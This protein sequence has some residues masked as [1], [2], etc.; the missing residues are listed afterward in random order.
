MET[1]LVGQ[2]LKDGSKLGQVA[3]SVSEIPRDCLNLGPLELRN[4]GGQELS[5]RDQPILVIVKN[6]KV[7]LGI[8][9]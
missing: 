6:F 3:N 2:L 4:D 8:V 7:P 5:E 9:L 1:W